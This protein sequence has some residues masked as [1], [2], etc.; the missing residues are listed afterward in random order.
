MASSSVVTW[1][2]RPPAE[3]LALSKLVRGL[4]DSTALCCPWSSST[5]SGHVRIR[6]ST[7]LIT[8]RLTGSISMAVEEHL[9]GRGGA[10][11]CEM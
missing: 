11:S 8:I 9:T 4:A 10:T 6:Q 1:A 2:V 7:L 3:A 5:E